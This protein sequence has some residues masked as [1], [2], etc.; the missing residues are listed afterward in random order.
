V[1]FVDKR[2]ILEF[3]FRGQIVNLEEFDF[4]NIVNI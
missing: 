1:I 2:G 4:S 3:D